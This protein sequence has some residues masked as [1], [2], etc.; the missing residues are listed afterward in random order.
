MSKKQII[1]SLHAKRLTA[2]KHVIY[3]LSDIPDQEW[4]YFSRQIGECGYNPNGLLVR[5]GEPMMNFF[6]I[7]SGLVRFYYSTENGK[8]FNKAFALENNF[9]GSFGADV[10]QEPCRFSIQALEQTEALVIPVQ[11]IR[12]GY[13]QHHCWERVGRKMAERVA[14]SKELREGEFLLDSAE[15]RYRRF[16]ATYPGLAERINQY[17]IASY[18]GITDVAL[19]R[20]RKNI[21]MTDIYKINQSELT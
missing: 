21:G 10:A 17:H 1:M 20:I 12:E 2:L 19:S 3:S 11:V 16:L 4:E 7:I 15:T 9:V 13:D 8:E 18:L 6:F 5:A 14:V